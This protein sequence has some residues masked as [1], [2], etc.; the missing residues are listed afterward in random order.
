MGSQARRLANLSA[1]ERHQVVRQNLAKIH[2]QV[3]Q[4]GMIGQMESWSWDNHRWSLGAWSLTKPYQH[5]SLYADIVAPE[6]RI[7]FAGEHTSTNPAWMQSAL[8]SAL[9]AVKA[10]LVKAQVSES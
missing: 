3:N 7:Y 6:C 4:Q 1:S 9:Q 8:E 2:T 5:T 10:V